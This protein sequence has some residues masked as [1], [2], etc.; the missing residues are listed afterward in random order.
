MRGAA[1]VHDLLGARAAVERVHRHDARVGVVGGRAACNSGLRGPGDAGGGNQIACV[2]PAVDA[3][4]ERADHEQDAA[5]PKRGEDQAED[6]GDQGERHE[7]DELG[8]HAARGVVER[9]EPEPHEGY[10]REYDEPEQG[11]GAAVVRR[12]R[13]ARFAC[14]T[15]RIVAG[16]G[17][18]VPAAEHAF[19]KRSGRFDRDLSCAWH[20]LRRG[21]RGRGR[22]VRAGA[23]RCGCDARA[24]GETLRCLC[25]GAMCIG[26]RVVC[27]GTVGCGG[28]ARN[29]GVRAGRG[30]GIRYGRRAGRG[31]GCLCPGLI[32]HGCPL[33][34]GWIG[35]ARIVHVAP[36]Q[37]MGLHA[38]GTRTRPGSVWPVSTMA[39]K[40]GRRALFNPGGA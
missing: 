28:V 35:S 25:A 11:G 14:G 8:H 5:A 39:T 37:T 6:G 22:N 40:R 10:G 2:P 30:H 9:D 27:G 12:L 13:R 24:V 17:R 18:S 38:S 21:V 31:S 19:A 7:R 1:G 3:E 16:K 26:R 23:Q 34:I 15:M 33:G 32:G 20:T 4:R 29:G 36:S